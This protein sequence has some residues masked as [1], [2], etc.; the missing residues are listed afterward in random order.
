M[1]QKFPVKVVTPGG[2]LGEFEPADYVGVDDGGTGAVDAP[3][4]RTNLGAASAVDLT[5]HENDVA[6][7]HSVTAAQAGAEPANANIQAHIADTANPHGVTA[8]QAGAIPITDKAAPN[9]VASLDVGGKVPVAQIPAT[10][11]PE[12]H[13]VA[14]EAARLAL[15]VQ[16]GDEAIQLDDG[17]HWIYDGTTWY[18]RPQPITFPLEILDDGVSVTVAAK[19]LNLVGFTITEPVADEVTAEVVIPDHA[20]AVSLFGADTNSAVYEVL[21]TLV[22]PGSD[23]VGVP[24]SIKAN[25]FV[26]GLGDVGDWRVYDVTNALA[27]GEVTGIVAIDVANIVDLGSLSNVSTGEAVWEIQGRETDQGKGAQFDFYSMTIN[28]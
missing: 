9:G 25:A 7:P 6:N 21:S 10:A 11:L 18:E 4:A 1:A 3:T 26:D 24:V 20:I 13:V 12:V 17:T 28:L 23:A 8:A 22:W 5:N 27:I 15:V 19:R 14:D 2:S 16:E